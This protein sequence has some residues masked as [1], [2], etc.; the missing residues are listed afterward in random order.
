MRIDRIKLV[1]LLAKKNVTSLQLAEHTGLSR[2]TISS[3][4]NGK[5]CTP[6]TAFKIAK[7]LGVDVTE[8]IAKED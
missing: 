4:K 7:A 3:I 5:S 6:S 1:M 8:I 2:T